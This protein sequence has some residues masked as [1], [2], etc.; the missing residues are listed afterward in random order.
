MINKTSFRLY[1]FATLMLFLGVMH[2]NAFAAEQ[3]TSD[4]F[5]IIGP[6]LSAEYQGSEDYSLVPMIVSN[7]QLAGVEMEVEGLVTRAKLYDSKAISL[8][9]SAEV[10]FGR[11][12]EVEN[13]TVQALTE[14][15]MAINFGVYAAYEKSSVILEDDSL[16]F[17]ASL[18]SDVSGVHDGAYLTVGTTYTLPLY[19]PWRF[20]FEL[21]STYA[22]SDYMSTYFGI[23]ATDSM[24]SGYSPYEASS[25]LRDITFSTNI[26]LFLNPEW[27]AFLRLSVTE[28]QGD[29]KNS[30][31]VLDGD[32]QQFFAGIG[33]FHRF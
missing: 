20:E 15:D 7:F 6:G 8:G 9:I 33:V 10:D 14:I 1:R 29:A 24:L 21:E 30:P 4:N 22:S 3:Q 31:I 18:F 16:E 5:L 19:I 17:R 23:D 32:S 2:Q 26:G 11:D 12:K 13:E 27:G 28:L 25:S